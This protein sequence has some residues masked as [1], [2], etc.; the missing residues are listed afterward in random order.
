[1]G[2]PVGLFWAV[3]NQKKLQRLILLNTLVY[4]QLHWFV[5]LFVAL[6]YV[7]GFKQWMT[8]AQGL[9][10]AMQ[11]GTR[12][13]IPEHIIKGYQAPFES[14]ISR[15]AL[16]LTLQRLDVKK[17]SFIASK[18]KDLRLPVQVIYGMND[19]A[20]PDVAR[21]MAKIKRDIPHAEIH[22]I[23]ECGHFLQEDEPAM[24]A[25]LIGGFLRREILS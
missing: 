24:V 11:L 23:I 6:S 17:L 3:N 7:P 8:S 10:V 16:L 25:N 1:M 14:K 22:P 15:D 12:R 9:K 21:T 2:G 13:V 4:P 20:L 19:V 5:K 18:L